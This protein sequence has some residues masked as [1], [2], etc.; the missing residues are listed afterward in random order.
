[1]GLPFI[2]G[3]VIE[4]EP[5]IK[6]LKVFKGEREQLDEADFLNKKILNMRTDKF[7]DDPK[8][9]PIVELIF[10]H[11]IPVAPFPEVERC[12]GIKPKDS[13]M[14]INDGYA[15]MSFDFSVK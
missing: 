1:M 5:T 9:K 12:L 7:W 11:K 8:I 6:E 15:L 10:G 4:F 13:M 2:F 3:K 14:T